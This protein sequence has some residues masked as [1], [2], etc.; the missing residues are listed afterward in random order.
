VIINYFIIP[1]NDLVFA[2]AWYQLLEKVAAKLHSPLFTTLFVLYEVMV[3]RSN[4]LEHSPMCS[5]M[6]STNN[7]SLRV[8][9]V[10]VLVK[11]WLGGL[12]LTI[13]VPIK[14]A[15]YLPETEYVHWARS[16]PV[17]TLQNF[18]LPIDTMWL[19]YLRQINLSSRHLWTL[20]EYSK[21]QVVG[22]VN[23]V[24]TM[25]GWKRKTRLETVEKIEAAP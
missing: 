16:H 6:P 18:H 23:L 19:L 17:R 7:C 14:Q 10:P 9:F 5:S 21:S 2:I 3:V 11:F 24:A 15:Y 20:Q 13:V 4:C 1:L 25:K 22:L 8:Y 12:L